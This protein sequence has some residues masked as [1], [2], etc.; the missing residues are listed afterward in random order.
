MLVPLGLLMF[1][2]AAYAVFDPPEEV[3]VDDGT[4]P[5]SARLSG[6]LPR[7]SLAGLMVRSIVVLGRLSSSAW[8]GARRAVPWSHRDRSG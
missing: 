1:A 5:R 3:V 4:A 7:N 6:W 2:I 8:R